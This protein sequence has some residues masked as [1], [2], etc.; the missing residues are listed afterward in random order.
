V[1]DV[2]AARTDACDAVKNRRQRPLILL[3]RA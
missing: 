3:Q 2:N 1:I